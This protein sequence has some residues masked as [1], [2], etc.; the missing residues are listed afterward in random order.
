[1]HDRGHLAIFQD[2]AYQLVACQFGN[3]CAGTVEFYA[4]LACI[5]ALP[6]LECSCSSLDV[7]DQ[8]LRHAYIRC[9][10]LHLGAHRRTWMGATF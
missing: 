4:L 10:A 1:M 9:C 6:I 5:I 3:H 7:H 2:M 8:G